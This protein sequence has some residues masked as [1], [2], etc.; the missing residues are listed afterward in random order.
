MTLDEIRRI[1]T[2]IAAEM[3]RRKIEHEPTP[4]L[5]SE[6]KALSSDFAGQIPT[7][8]SSVIELATVLRFL[9]GPHVLE[10]G[11]GVGMA[12]AVLRNSGLQVAGVDASRDVVDYGRQMGFEMYCCSAEDMRSVF[13]NDG[14]FDT[15]FSIQA[16]Q[17]CD[18]PEAVVRECS[19]L[20]EFTAVHLVPL[21]KVNGAKHCWETTEDLARQFPD[22]EIW[23]INSLNGALIS[24]KQSNIPSS[25][26][27]VVYSWGSSVTQKAAAQEG[28]ITITEGMVG[29]GVLQTHERGLS[30]LQT[31]ATR[32][33]GW[34]PVDVTAEDIRVLSA[35]S[36]GDWAGAIK[37]AEKG[38]SEKVASLTKGIDREKLSDGQKKVLAKVEPVSIHTDIRL[39]PDGKDWWEGGTAMTPGNQFR[40]NRLKDL[41]TEPIRWMFKTSGEEGD[42]P[43]KGPLAWMDVGKGGP[44]I[45]KPGGEGGTS[46]AFGRVTVRDSFRWKAGKQDPHYKEFVFQGDSLSGRY[47][48]TFMPTGEGEGEERIWVMRKPG[49]QKIS[50]GKE[51]KPQKSESSDGETEIRITDKARH[52]ISGVVLEPGDIDGLQLSP[53]DIEEACHRFN[54]RRVRPVWVEHRTAGN[55]CEIV[56]SSIAPDDMVVRDASAG[57]SIVRKGSWIVTIHVENPD[58]WSKIEAGEITGLSIRSLYEIQQ[59]ESIE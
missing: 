15:V 59:E 31:K 2:V 20:A 55:G 18:N 38:S 17:H 8:A 21:G 58:I 45:I 16:L 25:L 39:A 41:G 1:H 11:P 24:S 26:T 19:R 52:L 13:P 23:S 30:E 28:N 50:E 4:G 3:K 56:E 43:V 33:F 54:S 36:A 37:E 9:A 40:A 7:R 34:T 5:D 12:M 44:E 35:I 53:E 48:M 32:E 57:S 29:R 27:P 14:A 42:A 47:I 10:V 6:E 22:C 51:D 46:K 49:D